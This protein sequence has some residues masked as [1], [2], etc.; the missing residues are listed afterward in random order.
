M[1]SGVDG[2]VLPEV[3]SRAAVVVAL[4]ASEVSLA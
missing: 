2:H 3:E 1:N 4:A